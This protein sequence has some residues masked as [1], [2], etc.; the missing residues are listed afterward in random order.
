[1]GTIFFKKLTLIAAFIF[2][3]AAYATAPEIS[4]ILTVFNKEHQIDKVMHGILDCTLSPFELVV[5]FDGCT[6]R[7]EE[8][9]NT[10]LRKKKE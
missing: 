3:T 10:I 7:T 1:M 4:V 6:D 9:V 8:I 5:V 2:S